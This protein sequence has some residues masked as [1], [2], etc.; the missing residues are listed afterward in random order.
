M[1]L[2]LT[3]PVLGEFTLAAGIVLGAI[4]I[5][6]SVWSWFSSDYKKSQQ[7]KV[8]DKIL[9]KVCGIIEERVR[10]KIEDAK[11][12]ICEKV[13]SLKAGLNDPV[14]C[15]ERM[16]EGLIKAGEDLWH[17]SNNIKTRIAQ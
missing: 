9:D 2:L 8:V 6:K 4:G 12:G 15:Y 10:N 14:V 11:K 7:R 3:V 17:L 13:E 1:A 16:R 5:V